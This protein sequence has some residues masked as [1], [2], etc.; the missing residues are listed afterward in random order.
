VSENGVP[1]KL[2]GPKGEEV[3]GGQRKLIITFIITFFA[4]CYSDWTFQGQWDGPTYGTHV[5]WEILEEK[6]LYE[7]LTLVMRM[8]LKWIL[9]QDGKLWTG[10]IRLGTWTGGGLLWTRKWT[11]GFHK[12]LWTSW[13]AEQLLL[14]SQKWTLPHGVTYL[15]SLRLRTNLSVTCADFLSLACPISLVLIDLN[16]VIIFGEACKSWRLSL[17]NFLQ[18]ALTSPFVVPNILHRNQLL[19]SWERNYIYLYSLFHSAFVLDFIFSLSPE[20]HFLVFIVVLL[21]R[22][23][24]AHGRIDRSADPW[25]QLG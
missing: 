5:L 2:F 8:I 22:W 14:A 17:G 24:L 13:L 6:C 15:V 12:I 25:R 11:F 4:K 9:K 1:R 20:N 23:R 7:D 3:T 16:T 21:C 19:L 10:F 18:L